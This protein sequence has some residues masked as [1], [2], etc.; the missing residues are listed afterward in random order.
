[1]WIS[2]VDNSTVA[3]WGTVYITNDNWIHMSPK[4]HHSRPQRIKVSRPF[5][6]RSK[7]N[8]L[9]SAFLRFLKDG[10]KFRPSLRLGL[11]DRIVFRLR[12]RMVTLWWRMNPIV[13]GDVYRP[14][15]RDMIIPLNQTQLV[16][17]PTQLV[18][19]PSRSKFQDHLK[20]DQSLIL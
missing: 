3:C 11:I 10:V 14:H 6:E 19:D 5:K 17:N 20:K 12:S 7:F 4:R 9:I 15:V 16:L 1:M 2:L 13:I 8:P 18:R